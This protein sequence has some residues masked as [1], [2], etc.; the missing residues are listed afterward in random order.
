MNR[1]TLLRVVFAV[2]LA[3]SL[4]LE[5]LGEKKPPAAPWDYP[6]FFALAGAIGCVL[7]S[8]VAKGIVSPVLDREQAF[9]DADAREYD[10]LEA[11]FAAEGQGGT[12]SGPGPAAGPSGA[13]TGASG[14]GRS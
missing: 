13:G 4:G 5:L 2:A 6:L 11:R 1:S 12:A 3:G 8:V 14:P 7:L 10:D 9:Y